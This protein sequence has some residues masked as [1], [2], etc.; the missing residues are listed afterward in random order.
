MK[1]KTM[2]AAL[3]L[4]CAG[5]L[6]YAQKEAEAA[7]NPAA[8]LA[9]K[10]QR[11][12]AATLRDI[13]GGKLYTMDYTADYKLNEMLRA[14]AD[15]VRSCVAFIRENL[16]KGAP[17]I[18]PAI[19][20]GCSAFT[21]KT[22]GGRVLYGRNFDY[23]MEMTAVLLRT[24]PKDGYLSIG[25]VDAGWL[26]YGIGSLSDGRADLSMTV[27][28]PYM[29]MDGMNEKGLAVS[30]LKLDGEPARQRSGK[31]RI[32][33]SV[34]LRLMLDRAATVDEAVSLLDGYDMYSAMPDADF[35]FLAADASGRSVV[36]EYSAGKMS[37]LDA[38]YVTNFY[39]DPAMK[40]QGKGKDRYEILKSVLAFKKDI[41]SEKEAMALLA[42]VSQPETEESTSMTQWSV[43]YDLT[44][45]K[46]TV[47]IRRDYTKLFHFAPNDLDGN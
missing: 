13:D 23:K 32:M 6:P 2:L 5:A 8:Y 11:E 16:L 26:N 14:N 42:L 10:A 31:R 38:N 30:V 35:H 17:L 39:L 33:T 28:F 45:L 34:A 29:V 44:G 25:L 41:L 36:I 15:D 18:T 12:S 43:V 46:A 4:I 1:K 24:A 9:T 3:I 7:K 37:V 19:D 22:A 20:A 21:A 40:G 27:A 47:A